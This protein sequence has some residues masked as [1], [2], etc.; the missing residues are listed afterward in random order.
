MG[1]GAMVDAGLFARLG[2]AGATASS[3]E[4][5]LKSDTALDKRVFDLV[6]RNG[7][8]K[9]PFRTRSSTAVYFPAALRPLRLCNFLTGKLLRHNVSRLETA[10]SSQE[11]NG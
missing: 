7:A 4:V 8:S 9:S 6:I 2:Q 3:V 1:V 10:V 5:Q 11:Y